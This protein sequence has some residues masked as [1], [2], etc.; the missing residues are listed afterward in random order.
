MG[1][2]ASQ[3]FGAPPDVTEALTE[4]GAQGPFFGG[5]NIGWRNEVG[6]EQVGEFL[7][8]DAVI[9]VFA[10]VDGAHVKGVSQDEVE[11]G[12]LAR[13]GQPVPAEHAFAA[14]RQIV[15]IG[16]DEFEEELE[17]IVLDVGVDQFLAL[18]VHDADVHLPGVEVDSAIVFGGGGV[19]LHGSFQ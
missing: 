17:V 19:I 11:A 14:D 10:A 15:A 6:P 18:A 4:Q 16:G 1:V 12:G 2:D 3:E 13:V 9:L 5:I 7:R 8:I